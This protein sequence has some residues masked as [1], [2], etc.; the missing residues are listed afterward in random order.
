MFAMTVLASRTVLAAGRVIACPADAVMSVLYGDLVTCSIAAAQS[1]SYVFAG[2]EAERIVI[3][4]LSQGTGYPSVTVTDPAGTIVGQ[5]GGVWGARVDLSLSATGLYTVRVY[6][7]YTNGAVSYSVLVDRVSPISPAATRIALNQSVTGTIS[8]GGDADIYFAKGAAGDRWK[9][10]IA[11]VI[12]GGAPALEMYGPVGELLAN[13]IGG[14]FGGSVE[15][16]LQTTGSVAMRVSNANYR[17]TVAC[18]GVCAADPPSPPMRITT[19][20]PLPPAPIF[21]AYSI[22][23]TAT[24]GTLPYTSWTVSSGQLPP[25][26]SLNAITGV[27]SGTAT[28]LGDYAFTVQLRDWNGVLTSAN[29]RLVVSA[30]TSLFK[31][32]SDFTY[33]FQKNGIDLCGAACGRGFNVAVVDEV[34]GDVTAVRRFDT[35]ADETQFANLLAFLQSVDP[36]RIVMVSIADES[37]LYRRSSG[38]LAVVALFTSMGSRLIDSVNFRDSWIFVGRRGST[39]PLLE[40]VGRWIWSAGWEPISGAFTLQLPMQRTEVAAAPYVL[41]Q[42]NGTAAFGGAEFDGIGVGT[43]YP[44][45]PDT[46]DDPATHLV[47]VSDFDS[48]GRSD[49]LFQNRQ[50]GWIEVWMMARATVREKRVLA[51]NISSHW[52]VAGVGSFSADARRGVILQSETTARAEMW[53]FDG[54][55]FVSSQPLPDAVPADLTI[56][57]TADVNRDGNTDLLMRNRAT[58]AM[59]VWYM[60]GISRVQTQAIPIGAQNPTWDVVAVGDLTGDGRA[61]LVVR[62][63]TTGVHEVWVMFGTGFWRRVTI[64]RLAIGP[65]ARIVAAGPL[66]GVPRFTDAP[67]VAGVTTVKAVHLSE[68]RGRI[69]ELR[70]W[71]GLPPYSWTDAD[72][73]G[74]VIVKR[75]HLLELRQALS[76]VYVALGR[77]LPAFTDSVT[78]DPL[79]IKAVHISELRNAVA[80]VE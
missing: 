35:W 29:L 31:I 66:D 46:V 8:P 5:G 7:G 50:A 32:G 64:E 45:L 3:T 43:P 18:T 17:L 12:F 56:V 19:A 41:W 2:T 51:S 44:F 39:T 38:G 53:L 60:K 68:L 22:P 9:F 77:T 13:P 79:P 47:A 40:R 16:T 54:G 11:N 71:Q 80:V 74:G 33:S 21:Q 73:V 28:L 75:Q 59:E 61:D 30:S 20:S 69:D 78:T 57:G 23:L 49:L 26:L 1:R 52:R 63:P 37:G 67:I 36:N 15:V 34:T 6:E 70:T 4:A 76:D 62:N 42:D 72:L 10:T 24:G 65:N 14:F 48:D 55:T 27:L 58:G 25:G